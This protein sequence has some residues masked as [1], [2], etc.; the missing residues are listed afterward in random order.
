VF[1]DFRVNRSRDGPEE[2]LASYGGYLQA[3]G[4]AVYTSLVSD[5]AGRLID[6]ARWADGRRGF[7]QAL[8]TTS[9]LVVHEA[10]VCIQQLYD[11]E[12]RA[13]EFS[14]GERQ[15]LRE[16]EVVPILEPMKARFFEVRPTLRPKSKLAAAVDSVL[17]RWESFVRYTSDGR[18]PIDNNPIERLLRPVAVGRKNYLFFGSEKGGRRRRRSTRWYRVPAGTAW[19]YGRT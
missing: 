3:D 18:I 13:R 12:N 8:H 10:L 7:E 14:V 9:D 16:A 11:L 6:V 2:M 15:A 5:S 19:T 4:Y 1:Y 17:N